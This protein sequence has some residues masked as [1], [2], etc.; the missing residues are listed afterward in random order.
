MGFQRGGFKVGPFQREHLKMHK[1]GKPSVHVGPL[2]GGPQCRM[3]NLRNPHV[4]F[5]YFCYFHV[6]FKMGPCRMSIL[7]N[8]I[9]H[10]VCIFPPVDRPHVAMSRLGVK[11]SPCA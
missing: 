3:S 2:T 11:G 1:K 6:N 4:P 10:V 8:S 9:C 7:R 5:H